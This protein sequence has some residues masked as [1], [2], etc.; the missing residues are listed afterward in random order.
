MTTIELE[1]TYPK[2]K[3]FIKL[4]KSLDPDG[5]FLNTYLKRHLF[6]Q[7]DIKAKL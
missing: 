5:I 2:F 3:E 4:Q 1:R 6:N 7:M